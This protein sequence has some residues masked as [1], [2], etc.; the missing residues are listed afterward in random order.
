MQKAGDC[1]RDRLSI[2]TGEHYDQLYGKKLNFFFNY[3]I[4]K[5]NE[6]K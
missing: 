5:R 1:D 2:Y 6:K 3:V 4:F